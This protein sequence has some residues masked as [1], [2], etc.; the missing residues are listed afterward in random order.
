MI[1][2]R[3][4][5]KLKRD[6]QSLASNLGIPISTVINNSLREFVLNRKITFTEPFVPNIYTQE[7]LSKKIKDIRQGKNLVGPFSNTKDLMNS[8]NS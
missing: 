2:V 5:S 8:L 7:R 1:T 6:A 4:D 3:T